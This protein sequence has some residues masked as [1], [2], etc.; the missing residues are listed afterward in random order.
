MFN[1]FWFALAFCYLR[2]FNSFNITYSV[3]KWS[4]LFGPF[5]NPTEA[6]GELASVALVLALVPLLS[7]VS[8]IKIF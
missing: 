5:W 6:M 3:E 8:H 2:M 7:K 4:I 1:F